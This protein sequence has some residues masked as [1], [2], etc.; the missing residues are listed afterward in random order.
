MATDVPTLFAS[1]LPSNQWPTHR[2]A[3]TVLRKFL[4]TAVRS[5]DGRFALKF[6]QDCIVSVAGG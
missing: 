4:L 1:Q 5:T 6:F 3:W 2:V